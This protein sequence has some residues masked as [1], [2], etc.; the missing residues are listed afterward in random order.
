MLGIPYRAQDSRAHIV[1]HSGDHCQ[2]HPAHIHDGVGH[3][4]L[5]GRH[6]AQQHRSGENA[7]DGHY[8]A[9]CNGEDHRRVH[10][11]GGILRVARAVILRD[12]DR[13]ARGDAGEESDKQ[14][15][16]L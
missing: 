9:A 1:D 16:Y 14:I 12:D 15:E 10:R 4:V 13:C 7:D 5:W 2:I 8:S 6:D 3:R 11:A